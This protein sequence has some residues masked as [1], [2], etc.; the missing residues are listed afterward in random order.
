MK[1]YDSI[2]GKLHGIVELYMLSLI[3]I[4]GQIEVFMMNLNCEYIP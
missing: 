4:A 3:F 1:I 2:P